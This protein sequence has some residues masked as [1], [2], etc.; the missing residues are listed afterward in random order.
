[1]H[2]VGFYYKN[3]Y[4]YCSVSTIPGWVTLV[5]ITNTPMSMTARNNES[6]LLLLRVIAQPIQTIIPAITRKFDSREAET[7][8]AQKWD[9]LNWRMYKIWTE[10]R[11]AA[12]FKSKSKFS[13]WNVKWVPYVSVANRKVNGRDFLDDEFYSI[14]SAFICDRQLKWMKLWNVCLTALQRMPYTCRFTAW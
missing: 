8:C 13:K 14:T 1:V 5:F 11:T 3:M 2:L 6:V 4:L 7:T 9:P 12:L 10:E